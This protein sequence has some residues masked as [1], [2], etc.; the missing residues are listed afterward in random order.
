M[1]DLTNASTS[2]NDPLAY[3][4][5]KVIYYRIKAIL[6]KNNNEY[7]EYSNTVSIKV[8]TGTEVLEL[9]DRIDLEYLTT[10]PDP[11]NIDDLKIEYTVKENDII[12]FTLDTTTVLLNDNPVTIDP[13]DIVDNGDNTKT[14][15]IEVPKKDDDTFEASY[16]LNVTVFSSRNPNK[17]LENLNNALDGTIYAK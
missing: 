10:V 3:N 6:D 14:Y 15:N 16:K 4:E 7:T 5:D 12:Y 9:N 11:A 8:R 2:Y 13:D 17:S 1:I